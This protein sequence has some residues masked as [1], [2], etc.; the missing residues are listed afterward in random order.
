MNASQSLLAPAARVDKGRVHYFAVQAILGLMI[1]GVAFSFAEASGTTR[2][3]GYALPTVIS[4]ALGLA[5]MT[6]TMRPL[7]RP[8]MLGFVLAYSF[9]GLPGV[10]LSNDIDP[11]PGLVYA[12]ALL[13]RIITLLILLPSSPYI[14]LSGIAKSV[15][16]WF[17]F[18]CILISIGSMGH[19]ISSGASLASEVR[20]G[21]DRDWIQATLIGQY[22]ALL[23]IMAL[24]VQFPVWVRAPAAGLGLYLLILSQSR[25]PMLAAAVCTLIIIAF[26]WHKIRFKWVPAI[27]VPIAMFIAASPSLADLTE[28]VGQIGPI[29]R[30]LRRTQNDATSNRDELISAAWQQFQDRPM[31]GLGYKGGSFSDS[32]RTTYIENTLANAALE[33]GALSAILYMIVSCWGLAAFYQAAKWVRKNKI[34]D[35]G[36]RM[37]SEG[38]FVLMTFLVVRGLIARSTI[39]QQG[40]SFAN[41]MII[42]IGCLCFL[43]L[44]R[45][46]QNSA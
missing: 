6:S 16:N 19:A 38:G 13:P 22:S 4:L 37:L 14:T 9:S 44:R 2:I 32:D 28:S 20:L 23:Y 46:S 5:I 11:T 42:L 34:E 45:R 31:F 43:P 25:G 26:N 1:F 3:I 29:A 8:W 33:G 18:A 39:V 12:A 15:M 10:V 27:L 40:D 24:L 17:F 41:V 7:A 35:V 21:E 30:I 36:M